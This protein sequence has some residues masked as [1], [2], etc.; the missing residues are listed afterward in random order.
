[1]SIPYFNIDVKSLFLLFALFGAPI[2]AQCF[3]IE[4]TN[5]GRDDRSEKR[6]VPEKSVIPK[7]DSNSLKSQDNMKQD[8]T[9]PKDSTPM[10]TGETDGGRDDKSPRI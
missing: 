4:D 10:N 3:Q 8:D 9:H 5:G 2:N 1:M 7:E 6:T